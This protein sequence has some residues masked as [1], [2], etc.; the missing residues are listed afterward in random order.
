VDT[1]HTAV[2][3]LLEMV[4]DLASSTDDLLDLLIFLLVGLD[5]LVVFKLDHTHPDDLLF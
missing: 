5:I 1:L 4:V 2:Y 3:L